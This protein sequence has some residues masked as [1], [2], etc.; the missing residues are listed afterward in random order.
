VKR[1]SYIESALCLKVKLLYM[2]QIVLA[3][4]SVCLVCSSGDV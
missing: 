4:N 3:L 1:L 2:D